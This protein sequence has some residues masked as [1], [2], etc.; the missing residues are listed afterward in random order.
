M[1]INIFNKIKFKIKFNTP[2]ENKMEDFP[3][4]SLLGC[5]FMNILNLFK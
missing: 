3:I 4:L 2:T 1:F 5:E